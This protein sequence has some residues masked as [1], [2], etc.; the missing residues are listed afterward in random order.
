VLLFFLEVDRLLSIDKMEIT[1]D[2][3]NN[4]LSL[5]AAQSD[6]SMF[7]CQPKQEEVEQQQQQQQQQYNTNPSTQ[8]DQTMMITNKKRVKKT[9]TFPF[10]KWYVIIYSK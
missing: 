8:Y 2:V 5:H 1:F 3:S 4:F 6:S 7:F 10:G 9:V